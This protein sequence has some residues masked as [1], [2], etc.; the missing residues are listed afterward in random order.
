MI[1]IIDSSS[2]L[3]AVLG[4]ELGALHLQGGGSTV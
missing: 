3:L 1:V 2:F 4:F